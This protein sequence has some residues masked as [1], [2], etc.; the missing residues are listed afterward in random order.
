VAGL[1]K[2][3]A[4]ESWRLIIGLGMG[5]RGKIFF[6]S[7]KTVTLLLQQFFITTLI[8]KGRG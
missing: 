2:F 6:G 1:L 5:Q 8:K 4:L 3:H 7:L